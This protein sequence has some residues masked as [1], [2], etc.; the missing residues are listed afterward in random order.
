MAQPRSLTL[1]AGPVDCRVNPTDV[2]RLATGKPIGWF[3]RNLIGR[4]PL[5]MRAGCAASI[6]ALFSSG[7]S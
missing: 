6:P 4:V 1:M 5:P 7:P 3:E 2:N